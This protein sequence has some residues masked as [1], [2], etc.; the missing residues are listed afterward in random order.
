MD[1]RC[2]YDALQ[3][4]RQRA[5]A[6]ETIQRRLGLE[7]QRDVLA[8]IHRAEN[9]DDPV[10]LAAIMEGLAQVAN[11]LRVILPLHPRTRQR[12]AQQAGIQTG[13]VE[14]IDPIGFLDMV[15]LEMAAQAIITDSG[16]V[17]K[18]AFFHRVPCVTLRDE[19]EWVESVELGWNRL[20]SPT[21]AAAIAQ[22]ILGALGSRGREGVPYGDG[23]AAA[24]IAQ[25]LATR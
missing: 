25:S 24:R 20:V 23:S 8:T 2:D 10:R 21:A 19:T 15:Q 11:E 3:L 6:R 5:A 1:W 9:T 14:I 4:F 7:K 18:E 13:R 12:L 16:G 17:Q 22:S